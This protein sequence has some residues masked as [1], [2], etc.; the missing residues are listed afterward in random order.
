MSFTDKEGIECPKARK[1]YNQGLQARVWN[2]RALLSYTV[3]TPFQLST[4][5]LVEEK[6]LERTGQ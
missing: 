5:Y 3:P 4:I 1:E 2:Y 6:I